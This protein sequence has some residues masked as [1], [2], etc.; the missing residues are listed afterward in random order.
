M[1]KEEASRLERIVGMAYDYERAYHYA[2]SNS[3]GESYHKLLKDTYLAFD[4]L[5]DRLA[6]QIRGVKGEDIERVPAREYAEP[7][8][9]MDARQKLLVFAR[10]IKSSDRGIENLFAGFHEKANA[11]ADFFINVD[12]EGQWNRKK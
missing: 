6:E 4:D 9:P 12:R 8:S 10:G 5:G 7:E 3:E 1:D 2:H 11:L